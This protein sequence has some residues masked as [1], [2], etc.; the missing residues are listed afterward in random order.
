M[1]RRHFVS[2]CLAGFGLVLSAA[3][4]PATEWL[5]YGFNLERTG[6]N[7]FETVLTPA[8]VGGLHQ[9]WTFNLGAVTIMQPVLAEGVMVNGSPKTLVFMGAEHGDFYAI[10]ADTGTLVWQR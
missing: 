9:I 8:T 2:L 5:T 6:E 3:P 10:D 4:A 7:P 1:L